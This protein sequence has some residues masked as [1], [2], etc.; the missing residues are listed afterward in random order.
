MTPP[1]LSRDAP[2]PD[3]SH[4]LE[5]DPL[6]VLGDD[7]NTV[8]LHGLDRRDGELVHA[9]EP[10]QRDQWLDPLAGPVR[11]RNR[12]QVGLLGA[13]LPLLAERRNHRHLG[14]RRGQPG[15]PLARLLGHPAVLADHDDL[16]EPVS[17]ADLEVVRIV[18]RRDLQ[19][20]GPELRID[21]LVDDDLQATADQRQHAVAADQVA[22]SLVLGVDGDGGVG[23]HRLGAHGG[24]GQDSV[25]ALDRVVDLIEDVLHITILDLEIGDRRPR[26][27]VPV[28]HV[29]IA[30]DQAPVVEG[31]EHH[32]DGA[33]VAVVEG[34]ALALVVA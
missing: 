26:S 18:P 8:V 9:T 16:L 14:F 5:V 19:G 28:D 13:Q 17:A 7:P 32:V 20:A 31:L 15:E 2:R 24:N 30:V 3:V 25:G 11:E 4:P 27:R 1:E 12:V 23:E 29:V 21:V 34:E 33:D 22:V 6:V 10:L